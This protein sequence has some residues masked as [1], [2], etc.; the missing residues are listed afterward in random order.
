LSVGKQAAFPPS[1]A[2]GSEE[3]ITPRFSRKSF[4]KKILESP[5]PRLR[6]LNGLANASMRR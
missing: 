2:K 1:R 5:A 3:N 6:Q 4:L